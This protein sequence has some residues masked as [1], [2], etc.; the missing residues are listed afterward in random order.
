MLVIVCPG[1]GS[2]T[3]GFLNPWLEIPAFKES[4]E[5]SATASGLDLVGFG[6]LSDAETIK[7][8]AIAQPLI[9]SASI[10]SFAALKSSGLDSF[11]GVAGHSVGELAAASIAGVFDNS[12]AMKFVTKRGQEMAKAAA[13]TKSSMAAV[14][15]GDRDEVVKYLE[16]LGLSPANYNGSGQIV[17][18]GDAE[19]ISKLAAEP[20]AGTRVIPLAV[21]GAF[22]TNFMEPAVAEL[23][24][25]ASEISTNDPSVKLWTNRDGS[26][27]TDGSEYLQL[28]V[29]QV[30]NPVRWDLCMD[31]LVAAGVTALIELSPAGTLAGLAKRGMPGVETLA[32]KTP[33]QI[34]AAIALSK[35]HG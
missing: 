20:M 30:S 17:A 33:D 6:T 14:L 27:I 7:D 25:F 21:A 19:A 3:P 18:A 2:Q 26:L 29:S 10:A 13:K 5:S 1:Q 8:T 16:T 28:L 34:D 23:G 24:T 12:T 11:A 9:V 32:L 22:H 35:N 15:G 4:I 31:A